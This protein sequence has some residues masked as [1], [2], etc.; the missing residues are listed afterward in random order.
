[1]TLLPAHPLSPHARYVY[2]QILRVH[3]L[4]ALGRRV[5]AD[6]T[7][8]DIRGYFRQLETQGTS[9]ALGK[10]IKTVM[11]AMFQTAAEDGLIPA[12]V[13][14]GVRFQ[15]APAAAPAGSDGRPVV[16]RCAGT[17][18]ESTGCWRTSRW[19]QEPGSRRFAA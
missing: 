3:I 5:L 2:E 7:T 9:Q 15:A 12:N 4:V 16:R 19:P 6:V 10:K 18:P 17:S 8:A 11:S 13:V 1:M 14:R